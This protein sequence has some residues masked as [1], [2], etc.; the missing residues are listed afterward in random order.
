MAMAEECTHESL[1]VYIINMKV[2]ELQWTD[3]R[4]CSLERLEFEPRRILLF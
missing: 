3:T 4:V 1:K 2:S